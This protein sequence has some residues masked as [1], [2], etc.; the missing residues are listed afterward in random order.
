MP[1]FRELLTS[2]ERNDDEC[3]HRNQI[4]SEGRDDNINDD[5]RGN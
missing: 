4:A 1:T 3:V 2:E 5:M